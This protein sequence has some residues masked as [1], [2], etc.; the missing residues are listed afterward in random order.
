MFHTCNIHLSLRCEGSWSDVQ[1]IDTLGKRLRFWYNTTLGGPLYWHHVAARSVNV[2][3]LVNVNVHENVSFFV[4]GTITCTWDFAY[5]AL[6][7]SLTTNT[8][9]YPPPREARQNLP[10][11]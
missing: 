11:V 4:P 10:I 7:K 1:I 8:V 5:L 6:K 2:L 3:V 9:G